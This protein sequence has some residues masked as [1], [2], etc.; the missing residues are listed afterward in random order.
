MLHTRAKNGSP[1]PPSHPL[2]VKGR[3]DRDATSPS[4]PLSVDA[5]KGMEE[6][7][8]AKIWVIRV[9]PPFSSLMTKLD[10]IYGRRG[11]GGADDGCMA[12]LVTD[13]GKGE[14]GGL[15]PVVTIYVVQ[16]QAGIVLI[17]GVTHLIMRM[18]CSSS[19]DRYRGATHPPPPKRCA[20]EIRK[21]SQAT[22]SF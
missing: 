6:E 7:E 22:D 2:T 16:R 20:C 5:P 19:K 10:L 21:S 1:P 9:P 14:E 3:M 17:R 11:E 12:E 4:L 13:R 18:C 15:F 8:E